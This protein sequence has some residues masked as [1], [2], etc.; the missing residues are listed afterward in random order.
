MVIQDQYETGDFEDMNSK[1]SFIIYTSY[2]KNFSLLNM[3]QRGVLITAMMCYQLGKEMPE[4][5]ALTEMAFSFIKD[6]MDRNT[7][8]YEE[9]CEKNR[10]NG[11]RGGR[12]KTEKPNGYFENP[13]KPNG[14][15]EKPKKPNGYF[16]N[17][18]DNDNE[19][20]NEN[21]NDKKDILSDQ[22]SEI[23]GYLNQKLGTKYKT[24]KATTSMI[25]ARLDEGHTVDDFKTVI[26]K[27]VKAWQGSEMAQYLRPETLFRPSHFESYL[28]EIEPAA[29]GRSPN[30]YRDEKAKE[31][32]ISRTTYDKIHNFPERHYTKEQLEEMFFS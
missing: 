5:D 17:P 18:N 30:D 26:D 16:E 10:K 14:F 21:D 11:Q 4:M 19:Y 24:G 13:E 22:V 29:K 25:K 3:E 20:D 27:K 32:G 15:T 9:K 7:Q 6:D 23:I 1:E 28:N 31:M 2:E 8:S 12:P